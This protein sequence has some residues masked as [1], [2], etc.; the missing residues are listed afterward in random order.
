MAPQWV[1]DLVLGLDPAPFWF[2]FGTLAIG[3]PLLLYRGSQAFWRLRT[4]TDT[5][6][7]RIQSAPQGYVELAGLAR[8]HL[9]QVQ[10]PLTGRPCVWYRY[11][12]EERGSGRN[13]GWHRIE[14][15]ESP[16]PFQLD[17][18]SGQCLV[19]PT[20]AYVRLR[21]ADR[22]T[23]PHRSPRSVT[24]TKW[25]QASDQYRYVE[26]RID[27]GDPLY[28]LGRFET[29]LRGPAERDQLQRALLK[30]WKQDPARL[31][32]IDT[33]GDGTISQE[34]WEQARGAAAALAERAE[35]KLSAAPVLARLA[36]TGDERQPF[37][38]STY[39]E[40]DLAAT[41]RWQA[42]G[43]NAAFVAAAVAA[44]LAG[45]ARFGG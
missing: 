12:I 13:K 31:A 30:V 39:A 11:R 22:W 24:P 42:L 3:A 35:I 23:G 14:G 4:I 34:E 2:L 8:P 27:D 15:G 19:D 25:Y 5:P 45:L 9:G 18:G 20:G 6:T 16:G 36:A 17:D 21:R 43:Y 41:L 44:V 40:E 28:C 32:R 38:I 26:E 7:A 37:V 33:N 10:G 29:P 1:H